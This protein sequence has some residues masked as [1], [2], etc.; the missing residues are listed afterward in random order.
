MPLFG[1]A[2]GARQAGVKVACN[3]RLVP[4]CSVLA[5]AERKVLETVADLLTDQ[6]HST[7]TGIDS[8]GD[9][10]DRRQRGCC[11]RDSLRRMGGG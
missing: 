4:L 6:G 5:D 9:C 11:V 10:G 1:G 7:W 8:R 2:A 3:C